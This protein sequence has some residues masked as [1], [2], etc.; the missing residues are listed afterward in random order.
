LLS[1]CCLPNDEG[2]APPQYFFL[3]PPW[4]LA[5]YF[6]NSLST[7]YLSACWF[8]PGVDLTNI[9]PRVAVCIRHKTAYSL[10]LIRTTRVHSQGQFHCGRRLWFLLYHVITFRES[11]NH[12]VWLA[13][14]D[15]GQGTVHPNLWQIFEY[16]QNFWECF[17]HIYIYTVVQKN[18]TLLFF[19]NNFNK[20]WSMSIIFDRVTGVRVCCSRILINQGTSLG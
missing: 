17:V 11:E 19:K 16:F 3:E 13:Y 8:M 6:V 9:A 7:T 10:H 4:F 2:P 5:V 14:P 18:Q 1:R 15:G 20:Y 12:V